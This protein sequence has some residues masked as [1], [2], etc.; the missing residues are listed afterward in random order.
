MIPQTSAHFPDTL[1]K[2]W[3]NLQQYNHPPKKYSL[4]FYY[5]PQF[6][7]IQNI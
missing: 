2:Q 3:L 7:M 5:C 4:Y 6:Q 1:L